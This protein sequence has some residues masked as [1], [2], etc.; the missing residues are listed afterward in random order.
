MPNAKNT[1]AIAG[2]EIFSRPGGPPSLVRLNEE[3]ASEGHAAVSN[4][5]YRHYRT[6]ARHGRDEYLPINEL[7]MQIKHERLRPT[8]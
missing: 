3:L 4:R 6:L 2:W 1:D 8:G 7:D 5:M